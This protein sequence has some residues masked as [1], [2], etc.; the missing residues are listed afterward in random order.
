[1]RKKQHLRHDEVTLVIDEG[2]VMSRSTF[3]SAI[4]FI[5]LEF[6]WFCIMFMS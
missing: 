6:D 1:M 5:R 3:S 4:S 2:R